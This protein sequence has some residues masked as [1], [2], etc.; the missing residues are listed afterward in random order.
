M[1]RGGGVLARSV[2]KSFAQ[3]K[4]ETHRK[5][6]HGGVKCPARSL[7]TT[8]FGVRRRTKDRGCFEEETGVS[9]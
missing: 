8:P 3:S 1:A 7:V 2:R 9:K 5:Q 6:R 4:G